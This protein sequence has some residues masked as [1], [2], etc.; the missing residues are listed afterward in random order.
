M[1]IKLCCSGFSPPTFGVPGAI[2]IR[3]AILQITMQH[4]SYHSLP[5]Q[6]PGVLSIAKASSIHAKSTA[7]FTKVTKAWEGGGK[8]SY[9]WHFFLLN[10]E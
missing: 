5:V 1:L 4:L 9:Y 2:Q 3:E 8:V 7:T 6:L 10:I